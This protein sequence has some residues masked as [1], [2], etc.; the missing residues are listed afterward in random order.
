M[1]TVS[2]VNNNT[3][4]W[5]CLHIP[6]FMLAMRNCSSA[7]LKANQPSASRPDLNWV[8]RT[9]FCNLKLQIG[10]FYEVTGNTES[11]WDKVDCCFIFLYCFR[12]WRR[13][14]NGFAAIT[15]YRLKHHSCDAGGSGCSCV[16]YFLWVE[17][18]EWYKRYCLFSFFSRIQSIM[19]VVCNYRE[20]FKR[21]LEPCK[22][23]P[24]LCRHTGGIL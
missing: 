7:C 2:L 14:Q 11:H 17:H 6:I 9:L 8:S 3:N 4:S 12:L 5:Y 23:R 21:C 15:C 24:Y 10:G 13:I 19:F 18:R 1:T 16:L 22:R 20:M